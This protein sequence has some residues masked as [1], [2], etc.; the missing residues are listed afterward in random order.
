MDGSHFVSLDRLVYK[1]KK[2]G[3]DT[4]QIREEFVDYDNEDVDPVQNS[5]IYALIE[6]GNKW[7]ELTNFSRTKFV[8]GN[9]PSKP[10]TISGILALSPLYKSNAYMY[11]IWSANP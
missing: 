11:P 10:I 7:Q 4:R 3:R 9:F 8:E 5:P 2:A 1:V 6:E